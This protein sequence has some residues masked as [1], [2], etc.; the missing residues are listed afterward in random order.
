MSRTWLLTNTCYGQW[1]PG[2]DRGF[3]GH[4]WDHRDNDDDDD[5]RIVH[6]SYG[7]DFNVALP[8]LRD[9]A[10]AQMLGP[11]ITLNIDQAQVLMGQFRETA[12]HRNWSIPPSAE[13]SSAVLSSSSRE[14]S[15]VEA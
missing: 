6:N 7:I 13:P 1:L 9:T 4:V 10:A 5:A 8:Q 11:P 3:V 15:P 2:D 14:V 12:R